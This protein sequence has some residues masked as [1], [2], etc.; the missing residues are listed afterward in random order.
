VLTEGLD[1]SGEVQ[2][3]WSPDSQTIAFVVN[4]QDIHSDPTSEVYTMHADGTDLSQV[5][6]TGGANLDPRWS[7][8]GTQLVFYGYQP[9]AFDSENSADPD[10]FKTE[11]FRINA[12]GTN[13]V[14]LTQNPGLDFQPTWSPDGEW[15]AF[16]SNR[17]WEGE[18]RPGIFIM[19]PDGS[20]LQMITNEPTFAFVQG[21]GNITNPVWRPVPKD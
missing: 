19:R 9:G 14:D 5:T 12:D 11:V 21:G 6:D 3:Q 15:I 7:P 20:D 16:G 10:N 18:P 13:L 2:P 8:D 17:V 4:G 1:V